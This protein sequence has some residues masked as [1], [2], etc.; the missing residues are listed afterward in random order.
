MYLVDGVKIGWSHLKSNKTRLFLTILG[1]II[2]IA[3][4]VT[5]V[6]LTEGIGGGNC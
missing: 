1:I 3:A 5:L 6:A 2:S 4:V